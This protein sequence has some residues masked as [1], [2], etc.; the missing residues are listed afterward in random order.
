M[1]TLFWD[2]VFIHM[3]A[4]Y[5][6]WPAVMII[7]VSGHLIDH[8]LWTVDDYPTNHHDFMEILITCCELKCHITTI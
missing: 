6:T 1:L 5:F 4:N 8:Y 7:T 3:A 2:Y